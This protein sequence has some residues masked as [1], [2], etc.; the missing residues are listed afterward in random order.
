VI[1]DLADQMLLHH[2]G[3]VQLVARLVNANLIERKHLPTRR[4]VKEAMTENGAEPLE[5][6]TSHH[7]TNLLKQETLL[8]DVLKSLR[9]MAR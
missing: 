4:S 5:Y 2:N 8:A 7:I 1:K 9:H 3:A 6:L